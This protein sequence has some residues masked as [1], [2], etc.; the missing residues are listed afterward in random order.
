LKLKNQRP[1]RHDHVL[2]QKQ[3]HRREQEKTDPVLG[4]GLMSVNLRDMLQRHRRPDYF[5]KD[6]ARAGVLS[7]ELAVDMISLAFIV[8][9]VV[10]FSGFP[11]V[12][13]FVRPK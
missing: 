11:G 12:A 3:L 6:G 9:L 2:L 13:V 4:T 5:L 8:E 7:E 10:M 1:E